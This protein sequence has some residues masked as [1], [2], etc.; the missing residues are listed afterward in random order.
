M[1]TVS[2][3]SGLNFDPCPGKIAISVRVSL[4]PKTDY[5]DDGTPSLITVWVNSDTPTIAS[6][7]AAGNLL[8]SENDCT[9]CAQ[10]GFYQDVTGERSTNDYYYFKSDSAS[11]RCSWSSAQSCSDREEVIVRVNSN[12]D[13]LC[14]GA[15]QLINVYLDNNFT[16]QEGFTSNNIYTTD[17]IY[18]NA[19]TNDPPSGI[20]N[21]YLRTTDIALEESRGVWTREWTS[22]FGLG[23]TQVCSFVVTDPDPDPDPVSYYRYSVH[24]STASNPFSVCDAPLVVYYLEEGTSF[25]DGTRLFSN[26]N[27][28]NAPD[29][30]YKNYAGGMQPI[31]DNP[32]DDT[33]NSVFQISGGDGILTLTATT[34]SRSDNGPREIDDMD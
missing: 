20:I 15:G 31:P 5:C 25:G 27:G 21:G 33:S 32:D 17:G 2:N 10:T 19:T 4:N 26:V 28:T 34:C 7:Y 1:L 6:S 11:G 8:Y 16:P 13:P 3:K 23:N 29:A 9:A 12:R 22:R 14:G 30:Y 18:D 24:K